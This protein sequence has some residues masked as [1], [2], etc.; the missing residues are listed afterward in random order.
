MPL[1]LALRRNQKS[2]A[3]VQFQVFDDLCELKTKDLGETQPGM[4]SGNETETVGKDREPTP[5]QGRR[6]LL[7]WFGPLL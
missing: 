5:D 6:S 2:P 1:A 3:E 4:R 7:I